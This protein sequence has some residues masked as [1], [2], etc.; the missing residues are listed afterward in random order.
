MSQSSNQKQ[1]VTY[2][3]PVVP[4]KYDVIF[5]NDDVT[6]MDFVVEVMKK[7]FYLSSADATNLMLEV[8]LDGEAVVGTY[9][10]DIATSKATRTMQMAVAEGFPLK[11]TIQPTKDLPF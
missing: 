10:F 11:V 2:A 9:S 3:P 4:D 5:H 7:V 1:Q 8:H 6:T